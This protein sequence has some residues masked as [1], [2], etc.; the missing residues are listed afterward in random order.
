MYTN[1]L[2]Q[3]KAANLPISLALTYFDGTSMGIVQGCLDGVSLGTYLQTMAT[4]P[5]AYQ[6]YIN[7][8]MYVLSTFHIQLDAVFSTSDADLTDAQVAD[9]TLQLQGNPSAS[10]PVA[11]T[12]PAM[13]FSTL[14]KCK[15]DSTTCAG[16]FQF[17]Q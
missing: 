7:I 16:G 4:I 11:A 8:A 13:S 1:L 15:T 17:S 2:G 12:I 5:A 10:P 14:T 3:L 6:T 9:I